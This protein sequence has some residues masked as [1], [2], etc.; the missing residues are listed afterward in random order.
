[1]AGYAVYAGTGA[2]SETRKIATILVAD[3][4]GF[5]R[6]AGTDEIRTL[7]GSGGCKPICSLLPSPRITVE[8]SSAPV[9]VLSWSSAA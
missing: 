3:I 2:M 4:V 1:M 5:S 9:T 6:L 8:W 7:S